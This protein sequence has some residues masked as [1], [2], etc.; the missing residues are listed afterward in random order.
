[1]S[2][3]ACFLDSISL[4]LVTENDH[5]SNYCYCAKC[6]CGKHICPKPSP[7][8]YPK[9]IFTSFYKLNYKRPSLARTP[10][11]SVPP[12]RKSIFKL[13]AETTASH[14]YKAYPPDV[15]F[16]ISTPKPLAEAGR[17]RLSS[18]SVYKQDYANWGHM[19]AESTKNNNTSVGTGVKFSALSTYSAAFQSTQAIPA[20]IVKPKENTNILC[21]G[22][23]EK[24][25][26]TVMRSSY[27]KHRPIPS[28][29]IYRSDNTMT[30]PACPNQYSTINSINFNAKDITATIRRARKPMMNS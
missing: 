24:T 17:Y 2:K 9:S 3:A 12:R 19:K 28:E 25:P 1:M 13:E 14:D 23:E 21:T 7:K 6:T 29:P 27:S 15:S 5:L 8:L 4:D 26:E 11:T 30:L 16:N 20:R 18:S 22:K 10:N